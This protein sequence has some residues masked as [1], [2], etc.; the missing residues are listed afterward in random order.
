MTNS[1]IGGGNI[2]FNIHTDCH[3]KY[4]D[5]QLKSLIT[6]FM[7]G[8]CFILLFYMCKTVINVNIG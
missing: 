6:H 7:S 8:Q 4:I 2:A 3:V 1:K 5:K